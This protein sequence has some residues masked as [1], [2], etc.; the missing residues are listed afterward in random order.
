ML[1][2]MLWEWMGGGEGGDGGR[3]C[4]LNKVM[5]VGRFRA[6][7]GFN[8][9]LFSLVRFLGLALEESDVSVEADGFLMLT[10]RP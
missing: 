3:A 2:R 1:R 9:F 6:L 4:S 10:L 8:L 7:S 5:V